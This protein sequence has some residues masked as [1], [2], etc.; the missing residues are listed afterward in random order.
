MKLWSGR[1]QKN[2]DAAMDAFHSSISFDSRMYKEDI[3]GS[4]AHAKMLG[5]QG[6]ISQEDAEL[7]TNGL[8]SLLKDIEEGKVEFTVGAEDIHMNVETPCANSALRIPLVDKGIYG[9]HCP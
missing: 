9:F 8:L 7:I 2:T 5:R 6:I 3:L 1:F 4:V